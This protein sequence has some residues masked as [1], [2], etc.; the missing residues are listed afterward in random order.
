MPLELGHL[1]QEF[2]VFGVR[3]ET[4]H[5]FDAGADVRAAIEHRDL[6]PRGEMFDAALEVPLAALHLAGFLKR[7]HARTARVQVFHETPDRAALAGGVAPFEQDHDALAT[8]LH[9]GLQLQELDLQAILLP[10]VVLAR[11][12][13]LVRIRPLAPAGA[14]LGVRIEARSRG[15]DLFEQRPAQG[16]DLVRRCTR[17]QRLQLAQGLAGR[18]A[19]ARVRRQIRQHHFLHRVRGARA[20]RHPVGLGGAGAGAGQRVAGFDQIGRAHV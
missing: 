20:A 18:S 10:L 17:D 1:V 13:V 16:L 6:A 2:V 5:A 19:T 12:Q 4:H 11:H 7:D 3:A 8:V 9:R 14:E 15:L